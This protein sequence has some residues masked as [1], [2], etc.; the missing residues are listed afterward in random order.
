MYLRQFHAVLFG[1][2][3]EAE[4]PIVIVDAG[5]LGEAEE[6]A[7]MTGMEKGEDA[8]ALP[9]LKRYSNPFRWR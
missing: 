4:M 2:E 5:R 7:R 8:R 6:K 1:A 3:I 9:Y